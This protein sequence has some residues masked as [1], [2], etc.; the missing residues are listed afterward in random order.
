MAQQPVMQQTLFLPPRLAHI[1]LLLQ[2]CFFITSALRI[3][4]LSTYGT[5]TPPPHLLLICSHSSPS[6]PRFQPPS[7]RS[8][9]FTLRCCPSL[10]VTIAAAPSIRPLFP[11]GGLPPSPWRSLAPWLWRTAGRRCAAPLPPSPTGRGNES[12]PHGPDCMRTGP[13]LTC[14]YEPGE[15][16]CV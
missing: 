13:S 7:V 4:P 8:P 14:T 16:G 5:P 1:T 10:A 9:P 6:L 11:V 3:N 2:V 12:P 15:L